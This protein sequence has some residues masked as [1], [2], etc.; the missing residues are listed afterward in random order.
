MPYAL[1]SILAFM[2]TSLDIIDR[3]KGRPPRTFLPQALM[4]GLLNVAG[5]ILLYDLGNYIDTVKD[6]K[7]VMLRAL[8]IGVSYQI[9]IR[10]KLTTIGQ[11]PIGIEWFYEKVKGLFEWW[12]K[13]RVGKARLNRLP[14]LRQLSLDSAMTR[15]DDLLIASV[16]MGVDEKGHLRAWAVGIYADPHPDDW[17]KDTLVRKIIDIEIPDATV[18]G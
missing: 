1:A 5:A 17:K 13:E 7:N 14:E 15:F 2:G 10:S 9:I 3:W 8:L 11:Q 12:I 4:F 16:T 6:I 18:G